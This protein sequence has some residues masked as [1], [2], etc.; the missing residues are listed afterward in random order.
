MPAAPAAG[1]L[2]NLWRTAPLCG[3]CNAAVRKENDS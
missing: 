2:F 1:F 3:V